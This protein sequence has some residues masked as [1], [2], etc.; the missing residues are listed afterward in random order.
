MT[1][2][3]IIAIIVTVTLCILALCCVVSG[4]NW[5]LDGGNTVSSGSID[6]IRI[7]TSEATIYI[8]GMR[9]EINNLQLNRFL[10]TIKE[11]ER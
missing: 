5:F 2:K 11:L 4:I 8:K 3:E 6:E 9:S 1:V 7:E 10:E